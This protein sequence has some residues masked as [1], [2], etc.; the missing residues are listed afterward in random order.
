M[1]TVSSLSSASVSSQIS[2]VEARL[3]A[4]ITNLNTEITTDKSN[5]SAFGAISG[6]ISTLS[7]SLAGIKDVASINSRNATSTA[8]TVAT[9]S[10]AASA[11]AGTYDLS[12]I[13]LAKTQEIY[14]AVV[15]S[16]AAKL[17][18]GAGTL[19]FTLT[20]GKTESVAVGSGS[21]TLNGIAAAINTQAGG[22]QASVVGTSTGA[23]LVLQS[24][25][26]GSSQAFSVAGTG[27]LAK[28]SYAPGSAG[29]TE[30]LAQTASNAAFKVNGVP[31]T[32]TTNTLSSVVAGLTIK[33]AG[34]GEAT[35]T[36]SSAPTSLSTAVSSVAT[37][38]NAALSTIA[39]QIAYVPPSTNAASAAAA[40]SGPLLGNFTVT[41]LSNQLLTAVSAAAA[42]GVSAK[43]IGLS[44]SSAGAVSFDTSAFSTA[45]AKDPGAVQALV[46]QIYT[47]LQSISTAAI[48]GAGS[49]TTASTTVK[50]TGSLGA[51]TSSLTSEISSINAQI[52]QI[53][54][55]NNAQ[56]QIL[57]QE[58]TAAE[59]ASSKAQI[60]AAY[61]SIFNT[62]SSG[63]SSG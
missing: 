38:L 24:S 33:L 47:V 52:S 59:N 55:D 17:S 63:N 15:G 9:A 35:I 62:S 37:S 36:V 4:P 41:N 40:K 49:G 58:Y 11:A 34:S 25:A 32:S 42:S 57:V 30:T 14:S 46:S 61:L 8:T 54:K 50:S 19:N 5:I 31:V 43:A 45:Y 20:G 7:T 22:V 3:Q 13:T 1:S 48:G 10:A 44:V 53:S 28:F 2:Q 51:Q 6:A 26:T 56:L 18:G 12:N 29:T 23:R 60:S 16:A 21:L 27:A 39:K